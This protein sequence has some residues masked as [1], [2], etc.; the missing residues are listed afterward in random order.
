M[1]IQIKEGFKGQKLASLPPNIV[2]EFAEDPLISGLYVRK[3]GFFPR[4]KYHTVVKPMGVNYCMLIFCTE[5]CGWY[6][7]GNKRYEVS[8]NS[9][10]TL[11]PDEPYSFGAD[12]ET[13]WSIYWVHFEGT[14]ARRFLLD[15]PGPVRIQVQQNS[16]IDRRGDMFDEVYRNFSR[17]Y[18]KDYMIS[19]CMHLYPLLAS[20]RWPDQ[21]CYERYE[22]QDSIPTLSQRAIQ[23]MQECTRQNLTLEIIARHFNYSPSHFSSLF[24]QQTGMSPID[25]FLRIKMQK[26]CMYLELSKLKINEISSILSFSDSAYFTRIFTK[27]I[28]V[29]PTVY[30]RRESI[31]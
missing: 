14:L 30:R 3:I 6:E 17:G 11:P 9:Y 27:I 18:I 16:R 31:S 25:C 7:I 5:G 1:A 22:K 13:P 12:P 10:F 26:A 19:S 21:F 8:P 28:G 2:T 29:S 23:F 20:F 4:V 15:T 24:R